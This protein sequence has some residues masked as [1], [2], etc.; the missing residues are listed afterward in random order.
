MFSTKRNIWEDFFASRTNVAVAIL[1]G[2]S[3]FFSR[4]WCVT[5]KLI[6]DKDTSY[7][8]QGVFSTDEGGDVPA[9]DRISYNPGIELWVQPSWV[10]PVPT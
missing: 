7:I 9:Y 10:F 1:P 2:M 6:A 8:C 5:A 3:L 4:D